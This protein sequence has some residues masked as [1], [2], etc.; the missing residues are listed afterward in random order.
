MLH[1]ARRCPVRQNL[2][3]GVRECVVKSGLS[4]NGPHC[5]AAR[6]VLNYLNRDRK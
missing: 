3:L 4:G 2:R 6:D 5:Q 1:G